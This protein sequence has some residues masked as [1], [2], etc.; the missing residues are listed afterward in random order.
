MIKIVNAK[1]KIL[2]PL[3][4]FVMIEEPAECSV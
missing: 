1:F 4:Y 2:N 3:F